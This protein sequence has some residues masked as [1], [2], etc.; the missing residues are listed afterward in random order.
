MTWPDAVNGLFELTGGVFC[1]LNV[2]R[3]LRDK[4]V[5][6]VSITASAYFAAWGYWNMFYYPHLGQW[7]SFAGGLSVTLANTVWVG[8]AL[9]YWRR[10]RRQG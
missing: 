9:W 10:E 8:L 1:L 6:G 3:I 4:S 5:R 7:A 2:Q